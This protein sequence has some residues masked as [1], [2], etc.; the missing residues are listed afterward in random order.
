MKT[1]GNLFPEIKYSYCTGK[2][3]V[4]NTGL[5]LRA[6]G[7]GF[8]PATMTVVLGCYYWKIEEK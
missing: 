6:R 1:S 8:P 2:P 3:S 5:S 7:W 4:L